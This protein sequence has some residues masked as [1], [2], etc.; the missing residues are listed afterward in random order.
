MKQ[1][2]LSERHRSTADFFTNQILTGNYLPWSNTPSRRRKIH[3]SGCD[4]ATTGRSETEKELPRSARTGVLF[5]AL[6][7]NGLRPKNINDFSQRQD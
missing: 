4:P 2:S 1:N 3:P 5:I 7:F 6:Q